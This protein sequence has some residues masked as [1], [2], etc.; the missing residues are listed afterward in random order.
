MGDRAVLSVQEIPS[1]LLQHFHTN[2]SLNANGRPYVENKSLDSAVIASP[3]PVFSCI[4]HGRLKGHLTDHKSKQMHIC[5]AFQSNNISI[6][7]FR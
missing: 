7:M 6:A 5:F 1:H 2:S 3:A 4:F